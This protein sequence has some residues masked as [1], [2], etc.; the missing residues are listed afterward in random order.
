MRTA[1][2]PVSSMKMSAMEVERNMT[3]ML[4]LSLPALPLNSLMNTPQRS[5]L[6]NSGRTTCAAAKPRVAA[7]NHCRER[8]PH[9]VNH[10]ENLF[11]IP[12]M[13][14]PHRINRPS[15][16]TRLSRDQ[17][18][19]DPAFSPPAPNKADRSYSPNQKDLHQQN[20]NPQSHVSRTNE[21]PRHLL[22]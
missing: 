22:F 1:T 15:N 14:F 17:G 2:T 19:C 8:P 7:Q 21:S 9:F 18:L 12:R 3:E 6:C 11:A 10:E 4:S 13:Y 16:H 5:A 20:R